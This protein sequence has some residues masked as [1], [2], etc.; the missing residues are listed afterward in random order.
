MFEK[1]SKRVHLFYHAKCIWNLINLSKPR[2]YIGDVLKG[3]KIRDCIEV[4]WA[5][6]DTAWR[7]F[8][9]S[10]VNSVLG[11]QKNFWVEGYT[12]SS[13][14]IQPLCNLKKAVLEGIG[15]KQNIINAFGLVL[16]VSNNLIVSSGVAVTWRNVSLWGGL[17]SIPAPTVMNVVRCRSSGWM[18]TLWYPFQAS[19]TY[20][21]VPWGT[22]L[23]WWNCEK[24]VMGFACRVYV[25]WLKIYHAARFAIFLCAEHHAMAPCYRFTDGRRLYNSKPHVLIMSCLDILLPMYLD[26]DRWL[27]G[28]RFGIRFHHQ[29]HSVSSH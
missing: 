17:I 15:P 19:K 6:T 4:L 7:N 24:G 10:K 16:N 29:T 26:R 3:W 9:A 12:I 14:N 25:K 20:F 21:F 2:A 11:E 28:D 22:R 1:L 18:G 8:K 13:A 5:E 27:V 23:A